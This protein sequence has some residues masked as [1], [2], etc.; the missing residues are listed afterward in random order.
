MA[1]PPRVLRALDPAE[2]YFWLIWLLNGMSGVFYAYADRTFE[3][4]ELKNALAAIARRHPL[5]RAQIEV[6]DGDYA[7]VEVEGDIQI[8]VLPM[9]PDDPIPIAELQL[10]PQPQPP[11]PL[12]HCLY[13]PV[14]GEDRSVLILL[15]HHVYLDGS[16][17][18][19]LMRQFVRA[20]DGVE[21]DLG[22]SDE[23]PPPLHS[24]FP[25]EVASAR[26]AA[27]VLAAIRAE[28][29]GWPP[30]DNMPFH[31]RDVEATYPRHDMLVVSGDEF[32]ALRAEAKVA[33]ATVTGYIDAAFL[34]SA[35]ALFDDDA[36]HWIC[37]ASAT[38]LRP[39]VEPPLPFDDMY[40]AIGMLCTP[41]LVSASTRDTLASDIGEQIRREVDRG[42]SHLF[43]RFSRTATYAP[44]ADGLAAFVKWVD[45][46]PQNVTV[47]S[48]GVQD[49]TGDPPWVHRI[50]ATMVPGPNQLAFT[51]VTTYKGE[52]VLNVSMDVAKLSPEVADRFI[53]GLMTRLGARC[54]QTTTYRPEEAE[55]QRLRKSRVPSE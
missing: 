50:T 30:P 15:M 11:H 38:D 54:A 26:G 36:P 13:M 37:L 18:L 8:T 23:V 29:E 43:Y 7:F 53:E 3:E 16:S 45:S 14:T 41:Y 21:V 42:E 4:D 48:T 27:N 20:L 46:T 55:L 34:E 33:G 19:Y 6:V 35:A 10:W 32:A 9:A 1:T 25:P 51:S 5:L 2:K 44:D 49:A 28:R 22:S 52:M 17:G 47:S 39:R 24:R 12:M 40:L 31:H